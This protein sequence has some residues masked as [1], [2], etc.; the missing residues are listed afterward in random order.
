MQPDFQ[1][2]GSPTPKPFV[3]FAEPGKPVF[4]PNGFP[5]GM[6]PPPKTEIGPINNPAGKPGQQGLPASKPTIPTGKGVRGDNFGKRPIT[7][8]PNAPTPRTP[9]SGPPVPTVP[10]LVRKIIEYVLDPQPTSDGTLPD[11]EQKP[12]VD[13]PYPDGNSEPELEQRECLEILKYPQLQGRP[14]EGL[15]QITYYQVAGHPQTNFY[16]LPG[17]EVT[18]VARKTYISSECISLDSSNIGYNREIKEIGRETAPDNSRRYKIQVREGYRR[19]GDGLFV[20]GGWSTWLT[21]FL[22]L[23][24][25]PSMPSF[26]YLRSDSTNIFLQYAGTYYFDRFPIRAFPCSEEPKETQEP[27]DYDRK[28]DEDAMACKWQPA[29]NPRVE[30]LA[31]IE[32]EYLKFVGCKKKPDGEWDRFETAKMMVPELLKDS[33][34]QMLVDQNKALA[35]FCEMNTE[36]VAAI[37]EWWPNRIGSGRPQLIIQYAKK[38]D[39]GDYDSAKY[40]V[41][42]PHYKDDSKGTKAPNLSNIKPYEKGQYMG[43]LTLP[44]NSKLIINCKSPNEAKTVCSDLIRTTKY[45]LGD[46]EFTISERKGQNLK[47]DRVYPRVMKYFPQG[48]KDTKPLWIYHLP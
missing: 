20:W 46:C 39:N 35:T 11:Y 43:I 16:S 6:S 31:M 9:N 26:D 18:V 24:T 44:D 1:P 41:T 21:R 13:D 5:P 2:N 25:F 19:T 48:Q 34:K 15:T 23:S 45:A 14:G 40:V 37:P 32:I 42:I 36:A 33:I 8:P 27:D 47:E 17:G 28:E 4:K 29:N 22:P 10:F 38:K 3:P 7:R 30:S 12:E